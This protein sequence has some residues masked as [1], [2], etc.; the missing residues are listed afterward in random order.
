MNQRLSRHF[1]YAYKVHDGTIIHSHFI[2]LTK[3]EF[4]SSNCDNFDTSIC[5]ATQQQ[6][7]LFISPVLNYFRHH[8]NLHQLH[9][10]TNYLPIMHQYWNILNFRKL[11]FTRFR[12][13][14][15][16][17][18]AKRSAKL[19]EIRL[20]HMKQNAADVSPKLI[21]NRGI[22]KRILIGPQLCNRNRC[23]QMSLS[24][25]SRPH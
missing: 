11:A 17:D 13:R 16:F 20:E 14:D 12:C 25:P 21:G 19:H 23:S 8:I 1:A 7:R 24:I 18:V 9:S 10:H 5:V 6:T 3:K 4:Y 15:L 2:Y 22:L